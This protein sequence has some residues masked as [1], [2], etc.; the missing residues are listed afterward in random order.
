MDHDALVLF[1]ID[2]LAR[3]PRAYAGHRKGPRPVSYKINL[4][5]RRFGYGMGQI[6]GMSAYYIARDPT[7]L[8]AA[9]PT[10]EPTIWLDLDLIPGPATI[11]PCTITMD[12]DAIV[13]SMTDRLVRAPDA[14]VHVPSV[15]SPKYPSRGVEVIYL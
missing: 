2:R 3:S 4:R 13:C 11:S 1:T 6:T 14:D 7:M 5:F 8:R 10:R 12:H 15:G 9:R